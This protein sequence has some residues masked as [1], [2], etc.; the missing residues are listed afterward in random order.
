MSKEEIKKRYA[1]QSEF[2]RYP[3]G[4]SIW[5]AQELPSAIT[6][7]F[8]E[9]V[10]RWKKG[11]VSKPHIVKLSSGLQA[12]RIFYIVKVIRSHIASLNDYKVIMNLALQE[13]KQKVL[14][15]WLD[16]NLKVLVTILD[17]EYSGVLDE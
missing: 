1:N 2:K 14:K 12:I 5:V 13:K 15:K 11:D 17:E 7:R 6:K 10:N 16:D 4:N 3:H 9:S 8:E